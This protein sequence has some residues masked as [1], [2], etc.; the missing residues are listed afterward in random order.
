MNTYFNRVRPPMVE[1]PKGGKAQQQ[2]KNSVNINTIMEKARR[3]QELP[4]NQ[5]IAQ[6]GD[7]S[8]LPDFAKAQQIIVDSRQMFDELPFKIK[9]RFHQSPQ[10]LIQFMQDPENFE[11]ACS[12]GLLTKKEPEKPAEKQP[13]TP[14]EPPK[15]GEPV[16]K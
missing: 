14:A 4:L 7:V 16:T 10:E 5:R 11:E 12:L 8:D 9:K 3:G 1:R 13:E 6:Y 2:F 15:G